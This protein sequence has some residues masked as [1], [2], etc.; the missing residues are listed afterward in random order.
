MNYQ[1][2]MAQL[3]LVREA[4]SA[5]IRTPEE[6]TLM[7]GDLANLAQETLQ[8][9][10]LD[11]KNKVLNRH[12]ITLGIA[13][14]SLAHPREVFRAAITDGAIAI[15]LVHNHPS[16]DNTPSAEDVR[17]TR[18]IVESG[19]ILDVRVLDS[20]IIGRDS[21]GKAIGYSMRESGVVS[22]I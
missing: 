6:I 7:F 19:K 3:P 20:V 17:V 11:G 15:V 1:I 2:I 5:R 18:Q 22:F 8:V 14:A 9:V 12:I 16:G 21:D 13:D 10:T 4:T